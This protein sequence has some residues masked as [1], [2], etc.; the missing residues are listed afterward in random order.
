ML[1]LLSLTIAAL[2]AAAAAGQFLP[3]AA[4]VLAD[5]PPA[6][7]GAIAALA[8][9]L[10]ADLSLRTLDDGRTESRLR[11][12][13]AKSEALELELAAMRAGAPIATSPAQEAPAAFERLAQPTQGEVAS[14]RRF[15]LEPAPDQDPAAPAGTAPTPA[16][17]P[18]MAPPGPRS[19]SDES[20]REAVREALRGDRIAL[21]VQPIVD[22]SDRRARFQQCTSYLRTPTGTL[23]SPQVYKPIVEAEGLTAAIDNMLLLRCVQLVRNAQRRDRSVTY[24]CSI[25]GQSLSDRVFF[26]DFLDFASDNALLSDHLVFEIDHKTLASLPADAGRD[27]R[28]L[29]D[30]GYRFAIAN[31]DLSTIDAGLLT[32]HRVAFV[33]AR[34][35]DLAERATRDRHLIDLERPLLL[36]GADLIATH[37]ERDTHLSALANLPVSFG[38]G[39]L[40]GE[41]API[42]SLRID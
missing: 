40:F 41:P 3:D 38:Q 21:H 37:V 29:A 28:T 22:L 14:P 35:S 1:R 26:A 30:L 25:S 18:A 27:L 16:A 7:L 6:I 15:A 19:G 39:G 17:P 32:D 24:F 33:K 42:E 8:T 23:L 12:L 5:T 36:A 34:V 11:R 4:P 31:A 9:L 2:A 13:A 10:V 20:L